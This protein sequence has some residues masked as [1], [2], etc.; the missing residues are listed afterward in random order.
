MNARRRE[1][2][3]TN[4][5]AAAG[6]FKRPAARR[7]SRGSSAGGDA[8]PRHA[9][10]REG[11]ALCGWRLRRIARWCGWLP[12]DLAGA[13][14]G[15]RLRARS[16]RGSPERVRHG[17]VGRGVGSGRGVTLHPRGPRGRVCRVAEDGPRGRARGTG[18]GPRGRERC[19]GRGPRGR[20]ALELRRVCGCVRVRR[21][22]APEDGREQGLV[23]ARG[24]GAAG[25]HGAVHTELSTRS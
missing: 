2:C 15:G 17:L 11:R 6:S 25:L 10:A 4:A 8:S 3:L 24:E 21:P 22:P 7:R 12:S 19:G 14:G 13:V 16:G 1:D 5:V 20:L 9:G 18:Q 23:A